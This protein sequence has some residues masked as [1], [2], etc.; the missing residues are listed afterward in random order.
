MSIESLSGS[1][2]FSAVI[3]QEQGEYNQENSAEFNFAFINGADGEFDYFIQAIGST[4]PPGII[5]V[6]DTFVAEL[7]ELGTWSV[8][9]RSESSSA[10]YLEDNIITISDSLKTAFEELR[11]IE[12]S[13]C[14][15][16]EIIAGLDTIHYHLNIPPM[17]ARL[18]ISQFTG[19][20]PRNVEFNEV[21]AD[22]WFDKTNNYLVKFEVGLNAVEYSAEHN[23]EI[24]MA[25]RLELSSVD[26][27][28][29]TTPDYIR[30]LLIQHGLIEVNYI[31]DFVT[32]KE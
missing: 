29:L 17:L 9:A 3:S 31:Q 22:F 11:L 21:W 2:T 5:F 32:L 1:L 23:N 26:N 13:T 24:S 7:E 25:G 6:K 28:E 16:S 20:S 14:I 12:L 8:S 4:R 19:D 30:A 10:S 15:G 18:L 27:V